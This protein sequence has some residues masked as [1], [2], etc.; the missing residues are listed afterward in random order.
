MTRAIHCPECGEFIPIIGPIVKAEYCSQCEKLFPLSEMEEIEGKLVCSGCA[1]LIE[2]EE[3]VD[4][5]P[6]DM[7]ADELGA[8]R[9][10]RR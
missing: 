1:V 4:Y 3:F 7:E 10:E 9:G 2:D 8:F 5:Q 6:E